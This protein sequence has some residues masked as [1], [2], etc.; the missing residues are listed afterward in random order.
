MIL[1]L[2]CKK[3]A[4]FI[5]DVNPDT[6]YISI[7]VRPPAYKE[8]KAVSEEKI[9]QAWQIYQ[10]KGLHTELLTGFEGINAGYTGN[11]YEDILNISAVHPLREDTVEELLKNDNSGKETIDALIN[12][13]L[14]KCVTYNNHNYYIRNYHNLIN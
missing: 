11:A 7:P 5:A 6:A 13:G 8:V 12:Q 14:I 1:N 9:T 4:S 3:T 2:N 10:E